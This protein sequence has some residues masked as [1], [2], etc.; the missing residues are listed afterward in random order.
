MDS[1]LNK[2]AV[3]T[4]LKETDVAKILNVSVMKIRQFRSRNKGEGPVFI[5]IGKSIRYAPSDIAAF[6]ESA[7]YNTNAP[8]RE[9]IGL[10]EIFSKEN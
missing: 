5:R 7:K 9:Q 10:S 3:E 2:G 8:K 6:I 4:L 1:S